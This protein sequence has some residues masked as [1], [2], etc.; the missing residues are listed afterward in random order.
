MKADRRVLNAILRKMCKEN[1]V[2]IDN[3]F[4]SDFGYVQ[5]VDIRK[6]DVDYCTTIYKGKNYKCMYFSG[7]FNPYIVEI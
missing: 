6:K 1:E 2:D 3:V 7:C 5:T 4:I